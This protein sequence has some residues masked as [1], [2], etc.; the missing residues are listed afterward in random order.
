MDRIA[1]YPDAYIEYLAEFYGSRDFFECHEIMEAYWKRQ[2]GT[3]Y[4][5]SWLVFIRIAV[6]C[7]HARRGNW[8]GARKMMAKASSETD[9]ELM[10]ELGM[11]GAALSALLRDTSAEWL[12]S[13]RP[14]Y[15]DLELPIA[16]ESLAEAARQSCLAK[17]WTWRTPLETVPADVV[18]RHLTRDR[19]PVVEARRLS[20][21]RKQEARGLGSD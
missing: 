20:A 4:T 10:D 14:K 16:D 19:A 6:A 11:D 5:G 18:H 12:C 8:A 1:N 2:T 21:E 13:E 7:Y 3:R 15:R 17:G 9:P